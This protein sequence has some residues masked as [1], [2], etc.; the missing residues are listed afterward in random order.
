MSPF[1]SIII[2]VYNVAPYLREC[3]DSVLTQSFTDWEAVCVDDGS[4]DGSGAIL[5]EYAAK[6]P[7][8]MV[9]HQHNGGVSIARNKGLEVAKGRW[10]WFVDGDDM[11][12]QG[13]LAMVKSYANGIDKPN[14]IKIVPSRK[15]FETSVNCSVT[16][17]EPRPIKRSSENFW[18]YRL[19]VYRSIMQRDL[20]SDLRFLSKMAMGEDVLF[21]VLA[22]YRFKTEVCIDEPVYYYRNREGSAVN[23]TRSISVV[24]DLISLN[25]RLLRLFDEHDEMHNIEM[26]PFFRWNSSYLFYM[27]KLSLVK[28]P[29]PEMNRCYSSWL[30]LIKKADKFSRH[31]WW[32]RPLIRLFSAL[33]RPIFAKIVVNA[34]GALLRV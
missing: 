33:P 25:I 19:A 21:H 11:I 16:P 28:L 7:R 12:R 34:V 6:D 10:V 18:N 17:I 32:K 29:L 26:R 8:F 31:T 22:Y 3:L 4:T 2:P 5:D 9:I 24:R 13:C 30:R 1:F 27:D 20:I 23:Q 14:V 15:P